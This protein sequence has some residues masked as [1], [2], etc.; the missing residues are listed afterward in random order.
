VIA[1]PLELEPAEG[2]EAEAEAEEEAAA[3]DEGTETID[4]PTTLT[5]ATAALTRERPKMIDFIVTLKDSGCC[6]KV[7]KK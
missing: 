2:P 6:C 5:W 4:I 1:G 3:D 7:C